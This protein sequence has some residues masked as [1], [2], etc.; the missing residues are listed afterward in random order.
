MGKILYIASILFTLAGLIAL[1]VLACSNHPPQK[2]AASTVSSGG[3]WVSSASA[4]EGSNGAGVKIIK[5]VNGTDSG[6]KAWSDSFFGAAPRTP[7]STQ[8]VTASPDSWS[9]D[10]E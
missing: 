7:A 5:A 2:T 6:K 10:I 8:D 1:P 9:S 3:G 4:S